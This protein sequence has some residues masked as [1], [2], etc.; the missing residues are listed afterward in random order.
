MDQTIR[1]YTYSE[2]R[3]NLASLL[4]VALRPAPSGVS[5][6]DVEGVDLG[7]TTDEIVA[8]IR[9]GRKCAG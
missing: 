6:L 9:E 3:E 8:M 5:P 2:A 4:D 7:V 1:A